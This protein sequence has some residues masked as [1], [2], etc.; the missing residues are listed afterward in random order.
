[1]GQTERKKMIKKGVQ[2]LFP[3]LLGAAILWWTYRDFNFSRVWDVLNG[4]MNYGWMLFSLLFK[5]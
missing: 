1:M 2:I 4:G 3:L 5:K